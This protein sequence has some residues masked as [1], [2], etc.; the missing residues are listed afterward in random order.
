MILRYFHLFLVLLFSSFNVASQ[1]KTSKIV[2]SDDIEFIKISESAYVH[3]S[4]SEIPQFGMVSSNGLI[5][6][7]EKEA[8]LF[9]T[10]VTESQTE[11][12][13]SWLKEKMGISVIG[14]APNHW[15]GDCMGGL[16][17]LKSQNIKSYANQMTIDIANEKMLPVPDI[18]F[19][20]SLKLK[21]GKKDIELYYFGGAHSL[22]NIV[23]WIPSEK[24]LFPGCIV[25]SID[26]TS[27]GNLSDGDLKAY[28]KTLNMI[29]KRFR[30]AKFVIPG[31]GPI[32]GAELIEHTKEIILNHI[33]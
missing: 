17:Y 27:P 3:V 21:I 5:F 20:D 1:I 6:I 23:V 13:V 2:V 12:L 24:I 33:K 14:F 30:S 25:K 28:P 32:G 15:H 26:A 11:V 22:D 31:H 4:V 8:F 19:R 10:P 7:S 29:L 16:G 18:G 9:D